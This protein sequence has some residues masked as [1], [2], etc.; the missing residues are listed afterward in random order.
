MGTRYSR[1]STENR[2]RIQGAVGARSQLPS[3]TWMRTYRHRER[4]CRDADS[5]IGYRFCG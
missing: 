2:N 1:L 3:G 4:P 5:G